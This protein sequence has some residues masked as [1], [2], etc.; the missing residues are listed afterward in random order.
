MVHWWERFD[1]K[2]THRDNNLNNAVVIQEM[3]NVTFSVGVRKIDMHC[4]RVDMGHR[5]VSKMN[6]I[7]LGWVTGG[8]GNH[9]QV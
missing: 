2:V 8:L 4:C 6:T 5:R 7:D 1:C 9:A 3:N